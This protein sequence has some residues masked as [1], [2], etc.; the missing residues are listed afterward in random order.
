VDIVW[1]PL[2]DENTQDLILYTE[3][4]HKDGRVAK[5]VETKKG[6]K[7]RKRCNLKMIRKMIHK[8]IRKQ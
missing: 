8:M 5:K 4:P 2:L 1:R 7:E 6:R 3:V